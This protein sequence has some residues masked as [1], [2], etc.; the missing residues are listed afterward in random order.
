[1]F[2]VGSSREKAWAVLGSAWA[3]IGA[4]DF[5]A[6][7]PAS[8]TGGTLAFTFVYAMGG[9]TP[10]IV[11]L[12]CAGYEDTEMEGRTVAAS[13]SEANLCFMETATAS[14][15]VQAFQVTG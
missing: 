13:P 10:V 4:I 7:E 3:P 15:L 11:F 2:M 1:M 5:W 8:G 14:S 9:T 12:S 6:L